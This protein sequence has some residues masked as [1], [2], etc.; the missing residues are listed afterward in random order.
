VTLAGA[1]LLAVPLQ[2]DRDTARRWAEQELLGQEYQ[3]ARPGLVRR[4]WDW[5][6]EQLGKL[7]GPDVDVRVGLLVVTVVVLGIVGFVLWRSGGLHR[8]ARAS[9]PDL[10][11]DPELTADDHRRAA[12]DAQAAGDLSTAVLER[13]R[14]LVRALADRD[15]VQLAP[16]RTA[17]EA[18]RS[19]ARS[20]PGLADDL[21]A[22]ARTFDDVRY[23]DRR[24]G[25]EQVDALRE[26]DDRA[27]A[28]RP[29]VGADVGAGVGVR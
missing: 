8:T 13:F 23:G 25:I 14:A 15:L 12:A 27:A 6:S 24:P 28:T 3:A 21:L 1:A 17:D 19:A 20:L 29:T 2:P 16:G 7:T 18:A 5:L 26:L 10:L 4:L 9:A 22:A 11:G